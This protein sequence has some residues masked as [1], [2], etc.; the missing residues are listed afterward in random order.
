MGAALFS[1]SIIAALGSLINCVKGRC[2]KEACFQAHHLVNLVILAIGIMLNPSPDDGWVKTVATPLFESACVYWLY[3]GLFRHENPQN[4]ADRLN[5]RIEE[6]ENSVAIGL[7]DGYS[8]HF[9]DPRDS[10]LKTQGGLNLSFSQN[11]TGQQQTQFSF[12]PLNLPVTSDRTLV[13]A[14]ESDEVQ[15][16]KPG[17]KRTFSEM[18]FD[19]NKSM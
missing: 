16:A 9:L 18:T 13:H 4:E 19:D 10:L 2:A 17:K 12:A 15:D 1:S 14:N 7:A 6:L 8:W 5:R 3:Q 11:P